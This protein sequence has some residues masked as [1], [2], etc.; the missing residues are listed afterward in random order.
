[1]SGCF[2]SLSLNLHKCSNV[3]FWLAPVFCPESKDGTKWWPCVLR[4]EKAG[5]V[6]RNTSALIW[7]NQEEGKRCLDRM[8]VA[9]NKRV[10]QEISNI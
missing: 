9:K 1:M 8:K 10:Y 3:S 6:E 2:V 7:Y 4:T 5:G